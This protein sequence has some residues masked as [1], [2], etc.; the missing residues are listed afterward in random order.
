MLMGEKMVTP[1]PYLMKSVDSALT[2]S[3]FPMLIQTKQRSR[4]KTNVETFLILNF[5]LI[6][7]A[8]NNYNEITDNSP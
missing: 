8:T 6:F 2:V 1:E 3:T 4:I 5:R 7:S